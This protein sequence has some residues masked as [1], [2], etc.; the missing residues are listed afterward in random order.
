MVLN[1]AELNVRN[2]LALVHPRSARVCPFIKVVV[3][4]IIYF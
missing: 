3:A 1:G 4:G 2:F